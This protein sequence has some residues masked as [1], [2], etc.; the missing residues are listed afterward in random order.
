LCSTGLVQHK[1]GMGLSKPQFAF[2]SVAWRW[3]GGCHPAPPQHSAATADP[4]LRY[5]QSHRGRMSEA[6][7]RI[8]SVHEGESRRKP[9]R[10]THR[11]GQPKDADGER[12]RSTVRPEVRAKTEDSYQKRWKPLMIDDRPFIVPTE[13]KPSKRHTC[14]GS[15]LSSPD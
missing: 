10:R 14:L 3:F 7:A 12:G 11:A 13:T 6:A 2:S 8:S 5:R 4:Q 1:S 9:T 15:V